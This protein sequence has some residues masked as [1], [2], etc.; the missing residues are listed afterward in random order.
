M[1]LTMGVCSMRRLQQLPGRAQWLCRPGFGHSPHLS[2]VWA[3]VLWGPPLPVV[4]P[5]Q[6][7]ALY[8]CGVYIGVARLVGGIPTV[9]R[10]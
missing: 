1:R 5:C 6:V 7:A 2:G 8:V 3:H 9:G 4:S 10:A